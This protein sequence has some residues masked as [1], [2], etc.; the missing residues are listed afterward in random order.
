MPSLRAT[1]RFLESVTSA[2]YFSHP[3]RTASLYPPEMAMGSCGEIL[4]DDFNGL[5]TGWFIDSLRPQNATPTTHY[6][7]IFKQVKR[8][9]KAR[10]P[11]TP[12][13]EID[14]ASDTIARLVQNAIRD[15]KTRKAVS[16]KEKRQLLISSD[17]RCQICGFVFPADVVNRYLGGPAARTSYRLYDFLKQTRRSAKFTQI[18]IDHIQPISRGGTNTLS[19]YQLLCGFCNNVKKH[20][21]T[22]YDPS[23]NNVEIPHPKLGK[24]SLS[25]W[26]LVVRVIAGNN[27]HFCGKGAKEVELTVSPIVELTGASIVSDRINPVNIQ[28]NC[29]KCDPVKKYRHLAT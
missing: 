8:F 7:H 13:H 4:R 17:R 23:F 3:G 25:S 19:N 20:H 12:Q 29:Y 26:F 28:V 15:L 5:L 11:S 22:V 9:L 16:I 21:V 27:C 6:A 2:G 24:I 18:E 1:L 10:F 14:E